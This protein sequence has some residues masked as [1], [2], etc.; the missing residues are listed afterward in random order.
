MADKTKQAKFD[1][2]LGR[3][4]RDREFRMKLV[5][6]PKA[7]AAEVG[8]TEEEANLITGGLAIGNTLL[9]PGSVA[10]CTAKTCYEKGDSRSLDIDP[11]KKGGG[12]P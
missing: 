10:W 3:A 9:S 5:N 8:L 11:V 12:Q 4:I 6:N 2:I 7:T 1:E